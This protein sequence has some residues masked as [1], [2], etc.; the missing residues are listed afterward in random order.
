M[1]QLILNLKVFGLFF[2]IKVS[3]DQT[4]VLLVR[5]A[6]C[7]NIVIHGSCL[8]TIDWE[9]KTLSSQIID[10][11]V[12]SELSQNTNKTPVPKMKLFRFWPSWYGHQKQVHSWGQQSLCLSL[13]KGIFSK[14]LSL[15]QYLH[16][17]EFPNSKGGLLAL[18]LEGNWG[19]GG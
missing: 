8:S 10:Y 12:N 1:T 13:P 4:S 3:V 15:W 9:K 6:D 19:T 18:F 5:Y 14:L 7:Y 17:Q 16:S 2:K 11:P